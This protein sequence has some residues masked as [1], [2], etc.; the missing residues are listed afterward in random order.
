MAVVE[1][2]KAADWESW[3]EDRSGVL[4]DVREPMEWA[5]GVLPGAE[6]IRLMEIPQR[7][8][9]FDEDTP[10]LIVCRSGNRS[11]QAAAFLTNLGYHAANLSGGMAALGKA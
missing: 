6:K 10:Y 7:L 5:M 9:E 8:D 4:V 2:V 1:Q 11:Q 3:I